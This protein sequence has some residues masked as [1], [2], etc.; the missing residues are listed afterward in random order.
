ME[1]LEKSLMLQDSRAVEGAGKMNQINIEKAE[2]QKSLEEQ[3]EAK[4]T[5]ELELAESLEKVEGLGHSL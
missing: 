1:E 5:V 2:A 3:L 4:V